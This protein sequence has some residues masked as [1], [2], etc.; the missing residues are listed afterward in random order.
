MNF[1]K[2]NLFKIIQLQPFSINQYLHSILLQTYT[3]YNSEPVII[4][5]RFSELERN[6]VSSVFHALSRHLAGTRSCQVPNNVMITTQIDQ[7]IPKTKSIVRATQLPGAI[8]TMAEWIFLFIG[9]ICFT[10]IAQR[11]ASLACFH[12]V[13]ES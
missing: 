12:A 2:P 8:D 5:I 6:T 10:L 9:F 11:E 7:V 1:N 4:I 3:N 13:H